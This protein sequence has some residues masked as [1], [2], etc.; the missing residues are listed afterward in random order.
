MRFR[1]AALLL[2]LAL[3]PLVLT[4]PVA[5]GCEPDRA[6]IAGQMEIYAS[7]GAELVPAV[8]NQALGERAFLGKD[9][10]SLSRNPIPDRE[11]AAISA[12]RLKCTYWNAVGFLY[13]SGR[14]VRIEADAS[15]NVRAVSVSQFHKF[16]GVTYGTDA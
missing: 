16:L 12:T 14:L 10:H 2:P 6:S 11:C 13:S 9:I 5:C 4:A 3:I 8:K 7:Y 15:G 1:Y